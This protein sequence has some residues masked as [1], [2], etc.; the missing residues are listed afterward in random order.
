M[1]WS[2]VKGFGGDIKGIFMMRGIFR[3]SISS[4]SLRLVLG[5]S[6][7]SLTFELSVNVYVIY[8][9]VSPRPPCR[10]K[11]SQ[12]VSHHLFADGHRKVVF[13]IIDHELDAD[14]VGKDGGC[15]GFRKDGSIVLK[16][17]REGRECGEERACGLSKGARVVEDL[18]FQVERLRAR[19]VGCIVGV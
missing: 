11:L 14:E 19:A 4:P 15:S 6:V 7:H 5:F 2:I 1:V 12:L 9:P 8:S 10:C 17:V 13:A 18:P 16:M 3:T